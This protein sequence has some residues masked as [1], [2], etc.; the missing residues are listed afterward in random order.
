MNNLCDY[1]N[2]Y[3]SKDLYINVQSIFIYNS[4]KIKIK[5]GIG[6]QFHLLGRRKGKGNY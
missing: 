1:L 5:L 3:M 6:L 4:Q 2:I